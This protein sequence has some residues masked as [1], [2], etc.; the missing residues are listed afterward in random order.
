L[1]ALKDSTGIPGSTAFFDDLKD[2]DLVVMVGGDIAQTNPV[3]GYKLNWI[4][5]DKESQKLLVLNTK[6]TKYSKKADV[7]VICRKGTLSLLLNVISK[8]L[9]EKGNVDI[10]AKGFDSFKSEGAGFA[11]E[12]VLNICGIAKEDVT[13]VIDI[14]TGNKKAVFIL[15]SGVSE[16]KDY[17]AIF[18]AAANIAILNGSI[19]NKGSGILYLPEKCNSQ[20]LTDMGVNPSYLP[21]YVKSGVQG[22][23]TYELF[24]KIEDGSIKTL[25]VVGEDPILTYPNRDKVINAFKKVPNLIVSDLFLSETAKLAQ[26]VFPAASF[27]EK[28][29]TFTNFERRIQKITKANKN[30]GEA[31]EDLEIFTALENKLQG[32]WNYKTSLDVLAEIRNKVGIY[33]GIEIGECWPDKFENLPLEKLDLNLIWT[34]PSFKVHVPPD[35]EFE[36]ITGSVLNQNGILSFYNA[37]IRKIA[38]NGDVFFNPA[39]ARKLNI[40]AGELVKLTNGKLSVVLPVKKSNF[41][42]QNTVFVPYGLKETEMNGFFTEKGERVFVKIEKVK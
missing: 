21:G 38:G 32:S 16:V 4:K 15:S 17:S 9:L 35:G 3:V 30:I 27:A 23:G 14:V 11:I 42:T 18:Q 33:R 20:G 31:K 19:G 13:N 24:E 1:E 2:A 37:G 39:D 10:S 7:E 8:A 40:E 5:R 36:L 22:F 34:S 29:G 28:E 12:D 26:V 25:F 6:R 41:V